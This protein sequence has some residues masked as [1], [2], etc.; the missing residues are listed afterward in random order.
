MDSACGSRYGVPPAAKPETPADDDTT[1][2]GVA[3]CD[4]DAPATGDRDPVARGTGT[5]GDADTAGFRTLGRLRASQ[6]AS[7]PPATSAPQATTNSRSHSRRPRRIDEITAG[8]PS[9]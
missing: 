9:G 5:P 3:K 8:H 2:D 1:T 6:P 4:T 7:A